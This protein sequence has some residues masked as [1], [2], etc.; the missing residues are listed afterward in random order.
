MNP[1]IQQNQTT[2]VNLLLS[3]KREGMESLLVYMKEGGFFTSPGSTRYHGC[4]EGGLVVHSIGVYELL[5]SFAG[6]LSLECPA[7]SLIIAPLLHDLCKMGSY[8]GYEKPYGYNRSHP[9]GHA[10]LSIERISRFIKL[11]ELEEKMIQFHMGVYGLVEFQD[12]DKKHKGEYTL[13]N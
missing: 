9:K 6:L 4:Y 11:T 13:R 12:E 7:D 5:D 10:K 1:D 2:V 3:T 8:T